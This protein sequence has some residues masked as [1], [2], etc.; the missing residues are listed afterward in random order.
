MLVRK[1]KRPQLPHRSWKYDSPLRA[2]MEEDVDYNDIS[3]SEAVRPGR[4]AGTPDRRVADR[5]ARS[6]ATA[7]VSEGF[8]RGSES[9]RPCC[10][11][12]RAASLVQVP[13]LPL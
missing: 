4:T 3:R 7:R 8:W 6:R 10:L 9:I 11:V 5:P 1:A 2:R 13:L 12:Y